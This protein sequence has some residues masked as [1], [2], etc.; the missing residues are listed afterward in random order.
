MG[1]PFRGLPVEHAAKIASP[2][3]PQGQVNA[4]LEVV[5]WAILNQLVGMLA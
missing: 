3:C 5:K 4:I 2:A 1:M